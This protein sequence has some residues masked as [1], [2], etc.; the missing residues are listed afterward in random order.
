MKRDVAVIILYDSKKRILLQSKKENQWQYFGGGI[1]NGESPEN[2]V[3][4]EA[5]EELGYN[6]RDSKLIAKIPMRGRYEGHMDVFVE[7]YDGSKINLMEG[8]KLR[9]FDQKQTDKLNM[10]EHDKEALKRFFDHVG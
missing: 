5:I 4:R 3:K 8:K 10:S 1:Q 9:W 7:K 6:L 2:A